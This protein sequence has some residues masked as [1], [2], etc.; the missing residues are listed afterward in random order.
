M[1]NLKNNEAGPKFTYKKACKFLIINGVFC[2][3]L[4]F[5][6]LNILFSIIIVLFCCRYAFL[7]S[8]FNIVIKF[9]KRKD[10][11]SACHIYSI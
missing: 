3:F 4:F 9:P 8:M 7:L 2:I 11:K 1:Q 6:R 5:H 10:P